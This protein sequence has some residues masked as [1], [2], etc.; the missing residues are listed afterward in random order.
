[1]LF[2]ASEFAVFN[3]AAKRQM[4]FL[5]HPTPDVLTYQDRLSQIREAL[6]VPDFLELDWFLFQYVNAEEH[7]ATLAK[8]AS[9]VPPAPA[10][11]S[12][13]SFWKV[14]PEAVSC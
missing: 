9:D 3:D 13:P 4:A 2:H 6:E 1:M 8:R 14:A 11:A 10:V 12:A 5:N 7:E